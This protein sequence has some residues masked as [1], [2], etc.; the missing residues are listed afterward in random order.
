MK[1]M[2]LAAGYGTRLKPLT[3]HRPK[4]LVEIK[5]IPLIEI[6]IKRLIKF[7]FN[8]LIINLHHYTDQLKNFILSKNNFGINIQFSDE[9]EIL[10]DTGGGIYKARWFFDDGKP[11]LIYNVDILSDIDIKQLIDFHHKYNPLVTLALSKR[12]TNRKLLFDSQNQLCEWHNLTTGE[13][14]ISRL[15]VGKTKLLAYSGIHVIDPQLFDLIEENGVFSIMDVYLRLAQNH[16]IIGFEHKKKNW[17]DMGKYTQLVEFN[18][19]NDLD[20]LA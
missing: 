2:I 20:F 4:A 9:S 19:F 18:L 6:V 5:G 8:D 7:G 17:Y 3:N 13:K 15:P 10:L 1:A 16:S 11:F 14:K 12:V